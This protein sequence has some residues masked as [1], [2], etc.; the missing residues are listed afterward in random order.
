[1]LRKSCLPVWF[2]L[3]A[4]AAGLAFPST[5][6]SQDAIALTGKVTS[7]QEPVMEGVLVSARRDDSSITVTVVSNAQGIYSFPAGRLPAGHYAL[8]IRAVGYTLEGPQSADITANGTSTADLTL[9]GASAVAN[10]LSNGEW[11]NSLPGDE[12]TRAA[13]TNCVECHTLQR[14]VQSTHDAAEFIQVFQRMGT[15][16]PGSTPLFP[17]PLVAGGN[18]SNRSPMPKPIQQKMADYLAGVNLSRAD[19]LEFALK[20]FPRLTGRSTHVIITEYDLPRKGAQPHDVVMDR[21]G[22]V[23]YSDFSHQ[24]LGELDPATGKVTDYPIPTVRPQEPK[25]S[26]D[27]ELD[28][29][30]NL[31]L[32][33]MYQA[34]I[35]KFDPKTKEST[36]YPVPKEWLN[37]TTQ[38]SMVSPQHDDV[39]G[40]VWTNNQDTHLMYRLDL[41]SGKFEDLGQSIDKN[42]VQISAYGIPTDLQN[43]AYQLNF[44]GTLVGRVDAKT[45]QVTIWKTPLPFSRPRRGRVNAENVLWF[46]EYGV[47]GIGR[48]DPKTSAIKEW[49]LPTPWDDPYDVVESKDGEIWTGSMLTDRVARLDPKSDS[50][51][52][53]QLPR[54]TNIRRV[55]VDDR[56]PRPVLWVGSNHGASIV[57]IEPLD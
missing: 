46:A 29:Q 57:K 25:G 2:V 39:D 42:G 6:R 11:L 14:I 19:S 47:N 27:L 53:Y 3:I 44:G 41:A 34:A 50:I 26:L 18:N 21:D 37:A 49:L 38:E 55:F 20:P 7:A 52:E 17:Q 8:S 13:L 48:F 10:Q 31:W 35:L 32:A 54:S 24:M 22:M 45:K 5:A 23:W 36:V 51:T 12:R 4:S 16:A 40:K 33:M 43:D 30:G 56:G 28:P 1:M 15:Y 9:T